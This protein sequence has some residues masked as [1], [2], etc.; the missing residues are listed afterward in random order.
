L[1]KFFAKTQ[2]LGKRV[3]FLPECHSTNDIASN[4]LKEG[5]V[6]EGTTILTSNQTNGRGQRGNDW[7][8]EPGKNIT[9]SIVIKPNFVVAP[10]QFHL[11]IITTLAIYQVLFPILGKQLK[12]K[13]P[14]D[15]YFGDKKLGGI[16]IENTLRG[17]NIETAIIGIGINVNQISFNNP[18]ATSIQELTGTEEETNDLIEKIIIQLEQKFLTLKNHGISGLQKEYMRRLYQFEE[19]HSYSSNGISFNGKI[20]GITPHGKLLIQKDKETLEFD[21]KEISFLN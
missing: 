12:V 11:H 16:L 15:I 1:H 14:N 8:S 4:M 7:E 3:F 9:F 20:I 13:W 18:N 19:V 2:F 17:V 6:L 21:F 10:L 5:T